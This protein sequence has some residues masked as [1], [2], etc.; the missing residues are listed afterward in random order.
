MFVHKNLKSL[1]KNFETLNPFIDEPSFEKNP[2]MLFFTLLKN[3]LTF[4][5]LLDESSLPPLPPFLST[6]I[7]TSL[8]QELSMQ[9]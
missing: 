8:N 1:L 5:N 6:F 2:A 7:I 4:L 3:L 9:P